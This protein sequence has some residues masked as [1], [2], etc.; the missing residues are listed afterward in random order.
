MI[1]SYV[2]HWTAIRSGRVERVVAYK[3]DRLGRSITHLC[4]LTDELARLAG[5]Q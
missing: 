1:L 4:L 5:V 2:R 3:L